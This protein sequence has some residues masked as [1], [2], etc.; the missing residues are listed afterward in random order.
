MKR[1]MKWKSILAGGLVPLLTAG[2]AH[3]ETVAG[4]S[5]VERAL[6]GGAWVGVAQISAGH[7]LAVLVIGAAVLAAAIVVLRRR[8][9]VFD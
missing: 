4:G 1:R 8:N 2:T 6:P 7:M 9:R 3:A 5:P